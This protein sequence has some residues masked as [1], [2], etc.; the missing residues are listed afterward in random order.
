MKFCKIYFASDFT[1]FSLAFRYF[2]ASIQKSR[3][4]FECSFLK[5]SLF[6]VQKAQTP[7]IILGDKDQ[8]HPVRE[9]NVQGVSN[10]CLNTGRQ[11]SHFKRAFNPDLHILISFLVKDEIADVF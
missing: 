11:D 5:N 10:S 7:D 4:S 2:S 8:D 1:S 9:R 6:R 3:F